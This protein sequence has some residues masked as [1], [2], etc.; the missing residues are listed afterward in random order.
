MRD[1]AL[2][3]RRVTPAVAVVAL[4]ATGCEQVEQVQD[5]FRDLTPYE[6]YREALSDA[7]L[8]ETAVGHDWLAAGDRAVAAPLPVTLPFREEGVLP[9]ERPEAVAYRITLPRGRKL[10]AE[11]TLEAPDSTRVFVDLFRMPADEGDP[12]RPIVSVDSVPATFEYEPW[13]EGEYILRLQPELLRGGRYTVTLRT[14]AQLAFPVDGRDVRAIQSFFGAERDGGAR[15]HEGVDIFARRG[16][17][18]LAAAPGWAYRIG[19]TN[20]GGK[21]VWV[22]DPVRNMRVYYAHLDSQAVKNGDRIE[23]G[24]TLGFVGNT[25]NART[26]PPHL[27]FGIYRRGEG[28]VDPYW[29]VYRPARRPPRLVADTGL[30]GRWARTENERTY[31]RPGPETRGDPLLVLPRHTVLRVIAAVGDW[32]R[33]RLPDGLSGYVSARLTEPT[34]RAVATRS[35]TA[36]RPLLAR[37]ADPAAPQDVIAQIAVEEPLDVLGRFGDYLLVRAGGGVAGWLAEV[38]DASRGGS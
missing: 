35:A 30:L 27:H 37:P 18:V 10:T 12:L 16:T 15:S 7:G 38:G 23:V 6:A 2:R 3:G 26:T 25:G 22:R 19:V 21:V 11:V 5:S 14:E 36:T 4:V 9:F 34:T 28:P 13:R 8:L 32:Y 33:V 31:L 1:R 24:D 20:L 29:F 17:P